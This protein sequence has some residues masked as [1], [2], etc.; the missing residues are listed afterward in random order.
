M[1]WG[2]SYIVLFPKPKTGIVGHRM[3]MSGPKIG[4]R[5]PHRVRQERNIN[6]T[7]K[8]IIR[9]KKPRG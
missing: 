8:I 5:F 9:R 3:R 4:S 2:I 1:F 6:L 7:K